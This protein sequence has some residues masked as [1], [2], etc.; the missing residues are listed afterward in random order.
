MVSFYCSCGGKAKPLIPI[1]YPTQGSAEPH[2]IALQNPSEHKRIRKNMRWSLYPTG[3]FMP[4]GTPFS[5]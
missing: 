5:H 4:F 1:S 2:G 3:R